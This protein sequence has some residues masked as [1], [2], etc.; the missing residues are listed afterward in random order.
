MRQTSINPAMR[1]ELAARY[2]SGATIGDLAAWSGA[3]RQTVV[4]HLVRAGIELRRL[5]LTGKQAQIASDMYLD[6]FTLVEVAAELEV[7][8]STVR[9]CLHGQGVSLRPAARRRIE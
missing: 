7:A 5:G 9:R 3:H 2:E 1:A 6:G 4:R 8:A